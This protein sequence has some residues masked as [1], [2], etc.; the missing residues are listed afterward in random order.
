MKLL[1]ELIYLPAQLSA[2]ACELWHKV[3]ALVLGERCRYYPSCSQY[4]AQA[5]RQEGLLRGGLLAA[6]RICRCNAFFPGGF[7]PLPEPMGVAGEDRGSEFSEKAH[8]E[9]E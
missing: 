1:I 7:D 2:A 4:A 5:L 3:S 6:N 9:Q 8:G